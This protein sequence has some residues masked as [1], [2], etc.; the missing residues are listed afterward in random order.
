MTCDPVNQSIDPVKAH[1]DPEEFWVI[2]FQFFVFFHL[3]SHDEVHPYMHQSNFTEKYCL[4]KFVT[5]L[6]CSSWVSSVFVCNLAFWL[7]CWSSFFLVSGSYLHL[8]IC[9]LPA[10][11]DLCLWWFAKTSL[12]QLIFTFDCLCNTSPPPV[13]QH[14]FW[15]LQENNFTFNLLVTEELHLLF[16]CYNWSSPLTCLL[17]LI[18][19]LNLFIT[20]DLH[21]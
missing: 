6:V 11:L 13:S 17:Q 9:F 15:L 8:A 12:F 7:W 3:A 14:I 4:V 16:V 20:A 1:S 2:F 5:L 19:T 10:I 21:L 18:F